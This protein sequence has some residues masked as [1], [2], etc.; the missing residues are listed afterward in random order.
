M[1]FLV[2]EIAQSVV[3]LAHCP[4]LQVQPSSEFLV[5][6]I[7]SLK[8]YCGFC[9][10]FPKNSFGCEYKSRSSLCTQAF[11]HSDSK[12]PDIDVRDVWMLSTKTHLACTIHKDGMWLPL[13]VTY[14]IISPKMM[15]PRDIAGNAEEEEEEED[16]FF[17]HY[18][19]VLWCGVVWCDNS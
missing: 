16:L 14:T 18:R 2:A 4:A 8:S 3:C 19:Q 15:N 1:L 11:H 13:V 10:P 12:D 7:F 5:E 6:G 17:L 9:T